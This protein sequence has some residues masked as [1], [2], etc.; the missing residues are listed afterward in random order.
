MCPVINNDL[1][2]STLQHC[3]GGTAVHPKEMAG[4]WSTE[5]T[6]FLRFPPQVEQKQQRGSPPDVLGTA[7]WAPQQE[8]LWEKQ[9]PLRDLPHLQHH[10]GHELFFSL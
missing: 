9:P 2:P 5:T 7:W 4:P 8:G 3:L 1:Q 6:T 10:V